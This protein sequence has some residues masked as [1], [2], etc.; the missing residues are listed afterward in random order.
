MTD[1]RIGHGSIFRTDNGDSPGA[2]LAFGEVTSITPPGLSRD[3]IDA[4][5]NAS[6]GQAREFVAGLIDGGEVSLE[7]NLI[8]SSAS[9]AALMAEFA[10][11][12]SSALTARQIVF[13]DGA[14]WAFNAFLT[15]FEQEDPVDDKMSGTATYKISGLPVLTEAP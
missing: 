9:A 5:H 7:F 10:L 14:I 6:P 8:P 12:G 3:A 4:S 1:A 13:P 15:G 2:W 11:T